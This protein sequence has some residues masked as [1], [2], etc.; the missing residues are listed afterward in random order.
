MT[1]GQYT[2]Q[3]IESQP[4]VWALTIK[5]MLN[6]TE[7]LKNKLEAIKNSPFVVLGCGSTHYLAMHTASVLRRRGINAI[8]APSSEL[9]YFPLKQY[10]KGFNLIPI[11]RSGTTTETIWAINRY[12]KEFENGKIINITCEENTPMTQATDINLIASDAVERSVAQT[13]SFSSMVLLSQVLAGLLSDNNEIIANQ[14]KLPG[15][16]KNLIG[17]YKP[18]IEKLGG[19][20]SIERMFYLGDGPLFG[21]ASEAMLK[22]KEMSC[23]W[24]ETYHALEFRHGPMS[25]VTDKTLVVGLI[26]DIACEAEIMVL[27]EMKK[28]GA[29]T[30]AIMES[31]TG[32]DQSGID[33]VI[34]LNSGVNEIDRTALYLPLLQWLAFYRSLAKG[35]DPDNP[36]NLTK[37][38][39]LE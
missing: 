31:A 32:I 27:R 38:V 3:E 34:E 2:Y 6:E 5:K 7:A 9:V 35:L 24:V 18:F 21:I 26:S 37:V 22:A 39:F 23:S 10:Q 19:D 14:Q 17:K 29:R 20:L 8:H 4:E 11:S 28:L 1:T 15:I 16:L 25:L 30:L 33:D 13:R 12:K 36:V